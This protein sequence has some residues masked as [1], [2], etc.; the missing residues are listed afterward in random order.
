MTFE[1]KRWSDAAIVYVPPPP[2]RPEN[3]RWCGC[4]MWCDL[5]EGAVPVRHW[6]AACALAER[7]KALER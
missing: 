1:I 2:T 6:C 7:L 4:G 3:E 5:V